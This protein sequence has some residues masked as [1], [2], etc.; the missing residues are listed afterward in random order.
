M[1]RFGVEYRTEIDDDSDIR[2]EAAYVREFW[3]VH[4]S[5][6]VRP[7]NVKL[8]NIT[9]FPSPFGVAPISLPRHF[10]DSN[11]FRLGGEY[12]TK[13]IFTSNRIDIRAGA[14]YETSA[15]PQEWVSPLT[16][17]AAKIILGSGRLPDES[18]PGTRR[19]HAGHD[20]CAGFRELGTRRAADDPHRGLPRIRLRGAGRQRQQGQDGPT[21]GL[22]AR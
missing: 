18:Q 14:S 5:I 16:Y 20:L 6:D 1:L 4:D 13:K 8:F 9:G 22:C 17:D 2:V 15:I 21:V 12:S 7:E 11:S 3:S 10:Q 19:A